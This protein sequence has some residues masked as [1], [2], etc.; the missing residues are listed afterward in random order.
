MIK[1]RLQKKNK[2]IESILNLDLHIKKR[3]DLD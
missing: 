3:L 1:I 2:K